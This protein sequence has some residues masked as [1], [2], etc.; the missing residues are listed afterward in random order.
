MPTGPRMPDIQPPP[1]PQP[2]RIEV[3]VAAAMAKEAEAAKKRKGRMSTV[4][5]RD[6]LGVLNVGKNELTGA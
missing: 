6:G 5:T 1:K 4:A 3:D 2:K